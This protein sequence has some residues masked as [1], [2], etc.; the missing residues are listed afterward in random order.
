MTRRSIAIFSLL[1]AM[2]I[3][4]SPQLLL[5]ETLSASA[6]STPTTYEDE[7]IKITVQECIRKLQ[8]TV[9]QATLM[10]KSGDRAIFL[11][12]NNVRLVDFDGNE[13]HPSSVK[14]ANVVSDNNSVGTELV[15]NVPFKASFVFGKIPT[16]VNKYALLQ[17]PLGGGFSGIAKFRNVAIIDPTAPKPVKTATTPTPKATTTTATTI[18]DSDL[19]L[20]CPDNT[21]VLYRATSKTYLLYI[22]GGKNPTHYVALAKDGSQGIT[23]RLRYYDRTRFSADNGENN[24]TIANNKLIISKN[25]KAVYQEP[26][27]VLQALP[28]VSIA[29]EVTPKPKP[30]L[31]PVATVQQPTAK[32]KPKKL[33]SVTTTTTRKTVLTSP[34]TPKIK[35]P[36]PNTEPKTSEVKQ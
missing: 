1:G 16:N 34:S 17:I 18:T 3:C 19:S 9:C 14:L 5:A 28:G 15:E 4:L 25:T 2:S 32:Q 35:R 31:K 22:C 33:P 30:K 27:Q 12:G 26:I 23:L 11:N 10:S 6:K 29:E 7:K 36:Q 20:I 13:Y 21:K 8:E 24:Y